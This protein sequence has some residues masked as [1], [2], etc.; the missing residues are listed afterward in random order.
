MCGGGLPHV[1]VCIRAGSILSR[2][3]STSNINDPHPV[4][5]CD[6]VPEMTFIYGGMWPVTFHSDIQLL[7]T[8]IALK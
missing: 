1:D 7:S 6:F 8:E 2:G 3:P 5:V 4:H